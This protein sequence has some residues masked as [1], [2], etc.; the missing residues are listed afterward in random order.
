MKSRIQL[1]PVLVVDDDEENLELT[2]VLLKKARIPNPIITACSGEE[3]KDVL[4]KRCMACGARRFEKP[5]L[6]LLDIKMPGISGLDVLRWIRRKAA[7]RNVKV[8]MWTTSDDENDEKRAQELKADAYLQKFP[9]AAILGAIIRAVLEY[10]E[11]KP[12][13]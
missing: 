1:R 10:R 7:F 5:L 13:A 12:R 4:R 2:R 3:A 11:R 9:S 6:V 8:V